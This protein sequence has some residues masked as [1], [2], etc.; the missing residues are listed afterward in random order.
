MQE[1]N[2]LAEIQAHMDE[3]RQKLA[4][5]ADLYYNK[6]NPEIS[7][8]EYDALFR[9]LTELEAA[10][11]QFAAADSLTRNVGGSVSEKFSKVTHPVKMGS[12]TDVF[13]EGELRA[14]LERTVQTLLDEG[15]PAEEIL[16]TVEPK[17]DGLSVGLTYENGKLQLGATRGN[18]SVGENVTENLKTVQKNIEEACSRAGRD[19]EEVQYSGR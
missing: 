15:V 9:E 6:D 7:D 18:G 13:D 4:Y 16:F 3:L 14:F 1:K 11:P 5:H 10:H 2:N 12:L 17:I 8:Y 19:P